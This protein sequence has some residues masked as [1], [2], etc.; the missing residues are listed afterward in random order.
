M[1]RISGWSSVLM[2]TLLMAPS[3]E[4]QVS[5]GLTDTFDSDTEEWFTGGAC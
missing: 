2:A 1:A 4:A 3:A 5:T